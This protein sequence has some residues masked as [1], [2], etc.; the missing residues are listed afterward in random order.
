MDFRGGMTHTQT[1]IGQRLRMSQIQVSRLRSHALGYL[2]SRLLDLEGTSAAMNLTA[3]IRCVQRRHPGAGL[4]PRSVRS[5][6]LLPLVSK[7]QARY[8][9]RFSL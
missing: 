7:T 5:Q 8:R 9:R 3:R 1:Q 2:R 4:S 6:M